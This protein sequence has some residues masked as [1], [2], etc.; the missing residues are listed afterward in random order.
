[1]SVNHLQFQFYK[2]QIIF[3][4]LPV[5][6]PFYL[7]G[8]SRATASQSGLALSVMT[9]FLAMASL[10]YRRIASWFDHFGVLTLA[11]ALIGAGYLLISI[12]GGWAIIVLGLLLG[13]KGRA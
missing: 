13:G 12:A 2:T 5:Q 4:L 11:F 10:Q 3:Y 8:L 9:F 6:L 1:M 7:Q